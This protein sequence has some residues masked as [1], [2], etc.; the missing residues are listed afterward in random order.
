MTPTIAKYLESI[1]FGAKLEGAEECDMLSEIKTH[2][3]DRIQEL[4]DSGLSEEDAVNTCLGQMGNPQSVSR[5]IYEAYSQGSWK[6]V[7]LASTPHI[8]FGGLFA[9]NWWQHIG[10][11]SALLLL[12]LAATVY[13]WWHGKPAWVFSWLG[14]SLLPVL[15]V[16]IILLYLPRG[17]SFIVIPIYLPLALWWLITIVVQTIRRDW[18]FSSLMLLPLPI[19]IGWFLAIFPGARLNESGLQRVYLFAPG[20]GLSFMALA[21]TIATFIRIRQRRLRVALLAVS[22]LVTLSLVTFYSFEKLN[23]PTFLGLI[24]IM[25][26]ILLAPLLI[27]RYLHNRRQRLPDAI[28]SSTADVN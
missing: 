7:M 26:A 25:W 20:I 22:G 3:E 8:L 2:I 5:R 21:L 27:E 15:I 13:G 9:L 4:L 24:F 17:W 28:R 18:L 14:Y 11:L 6:Q 1:R 16:G 12:V 23:I 10:W 19:I